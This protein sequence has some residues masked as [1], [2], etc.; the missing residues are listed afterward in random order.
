M[1]FELIL[2]P[3]AEAELSDAFAWYEKNRPGLGG[4]FMLAAEATLAEVR[5][6]P[7]SFQKVR[8]EVR[9][10][11]CGGSPTRSSSS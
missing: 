1:T 4:E 2:R 11:L 3:E 6:L 8:A 7:E 5:R 9:R 10:A